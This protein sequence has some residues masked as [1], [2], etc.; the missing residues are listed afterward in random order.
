MRHPYPTVALPLGAL[1]VSLAL[2]VA[3]CATATPPGPGAEVGSTARLVRVVDGDTI[4]VDIAG[5]EETVRLIGIDTPESVK[6]DSAVECFGPEASH[7]LARLV[8]PG[9]AL[10]LARDQELRDRYERLLAYVFRLPDEMF[11]NLEMAATGYAAPLPFAPNLTFADDMAAAVS[12]A[13]RAGLGLWSAC[14]DPDSLFG[15]V[16][17]Q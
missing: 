16:R 1:F 14:P 15:S 17:V 13:R 11:L 4:V 2:A 9:T 12:A 7:E 3:G 5:R 8:P 6:P 10:R